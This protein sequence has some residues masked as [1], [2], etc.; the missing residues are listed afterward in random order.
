MQVSATLEDTRFVNRHM[1][2][3][4]HTLEEG[5]RLSDGTLIHIDLRVD[6]CDGQQEAKDAGCSSGASHHSCSVCDANIHGHADLTGCLKRHLRTLTSL[7]ERALT[8]AGVGGFEERIDLRGSRKAPLVE[9]VHKLGGESVG[10]LKA[11]EVLAKAQDLLRGQVGDPGIKGG[12]TL[13]DLPMLTGRSGHAGMEFVY[14]VSLH[15]TTGQTK[16]GKEKLHRLLSKADRATLAMIEKQVLGDK[17]H[18]TGADA[19]LWLYALPWMLRQQRLVSASEGRALHMVRAL[20]CWARL[21]VVCLRVRYNTWYNNYHGCVLRATGLF[22]QFTHHAKLAVP[23]TSKKGRVDTFWLTY[24]HQAMHALEYIQYMPACLSECEQCEG[25]FRPLRE[26]AKNSSR[27][28]QNMI[29]SMLAGLQM[30]QHV[31]ELY[32]TEGEAGHTDHRFHQH[33]IKSF[34]TADAEHMRFTRA[35]WEGDGNWA[36]LVTMLAPFLVHR[37]CWHIEGLGD[38]AVFVLHTGDLAIWLPTERLD[39]ARHTLADVRGRAKSALETLRAQTTDPLERRVLGLECAG[40]TARPTVAPVA[41]GPASGGGGEMGDDDSDEDNSDA[42]ENSDDSDEEDGGD[43]RAAGRGGFAPD[44]YVLS[45]RS[46]AGEVLSMKKL[47]GHGVTT[48]RWERRERGGVRFITYAGEHTR[49]ADGESARDGHGVERTATGARVQ[50]Q[51]ELGCFRGHGEMEMSTGEVHRGRFEVDGVTGQSVLQGWGWK[52]LSADSPE[53]HEQGEYAAGELRAEGAPPT[54]EEQAVEAALELAAEAEAAGHAAR[55]AQLRAAEAA[56]RA[57]EPN[58]PEQP[59]A[60]PFESSA[61]KWLRKTLADDEQGL[62]DTYETARRGDDDAATTRALHVALEKA[63]LQYLRDENSIQQHERAGGLSW[64]GAEKGVGVLTTASARATYL[65]RCS[66]DRVY[67]THGYSLPAFTRKRLAG[68]EKLKWLQ[69]EADL[70]RVDLAALFEKCK[71][72][73][74]KVQRPSSQN[75]AKR[76]SGA[77]MVSGVIGSERV[78]QALMPTEAERLQRTVDDLQKKL[79]DALAAQAAGA[80]KPPVQTAQARSSAAA[81]PTLSRGARMQ[82]LS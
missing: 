56:E 71:L 32:N 58:A 33:Y 48:E 23:T 43:G 65:R 19:R 82:R 74:E 54:A 25:L 51:W 53:P 21:H 14:D 63:A 10:H 55:R 26:L 1:M 79:A 73:K 6:K 9:L 76:P 35:Q 80:S 47:T 11:P 29:E 18:Y 81:R 46:Y 37:A 66:T 12:L 40:A 13:A 72:R 69:G 61:A 49:N 31:K 60:A 41:I 67:S 50:G 38:E 59:A 39:Y 28:L 5:V 64:K 62:V 78:R 36:W 27:H 17:S 45:C 42:D 57:P 8:C 2:L 16:E 68:T 20:E 70:Q 15:A 22:L 75:P 7:S 4:L 24:Y 77:Q 3:D 44:P 30:E 52:Y 34:P